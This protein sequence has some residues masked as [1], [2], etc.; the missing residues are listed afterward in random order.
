MMDT[1]VEIKHITKVLEKCRVLDDVTFKIP[2]GCIYGLLGNNGAGKT[3]LMRIL[4]GLAKPTQGTVQYLEKPI[5]LGGLIEHPALYSDMTAYENIYMATCIYGTNH[6]DILHIMDALELS[7][8]SKKK[9]CQLSLGNRQRVGLA[10]AI[11]GNPDFLVLDEPLNGLDP[12]GI[13]LVR[14]L[15][16][17]WKKEGRTIL[18]SSHILSELFLVADYYGIM[19][20]GR[21]K[22]EISAE[23]IMNCGSEY[24][25]CEAY[26]LGHMKR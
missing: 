7:Y 22:E 16:L 10:M 6:A 14:Q 13:R 25:I 8:T 23:Q 12:S 26:I 9:I 15:L 18:V 17:E 21:Y 2:K 11:A 3:T 5:R 24:K 1:L 4:L 19:L 20:D